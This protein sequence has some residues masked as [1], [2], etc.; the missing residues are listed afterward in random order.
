MQNALMIIW[1]VCCGTKFVAAAPYFH[2]SSFLYQT[3]PEIGM[4]IAIKASALS[5]VLFPFRE[6]MPYSVTIM[7]TAV[8]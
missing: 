4:A 8:R 3:I 5:Q 2:L 7:C 1:L 6:A